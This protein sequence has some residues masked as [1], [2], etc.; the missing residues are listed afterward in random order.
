[1]RRWY[2]E[3]ERFA[4]T[5]KRP[6][7]R[8]GVSKMGDYFSAIADY[9][10]GIFAVEHIPAYTYVGIYAGEYLTDQEGHQRGQYVIYWFWY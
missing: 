1:M 2:S 3:V 5:S 4:L 10:S 7:R 8:A 6:T 9:G